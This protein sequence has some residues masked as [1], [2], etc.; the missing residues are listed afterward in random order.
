MYA[1]MT[2][3][4]KSLINRHFGTYLHNIINV[5][6][7]RVSQLKCGEYFYDDV[8]PYYRGVALDRAGKNRGIPLGSFASKSVLVN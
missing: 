4:A 1:K 7:S 2:T 3:F 5:I 8:M 6:S